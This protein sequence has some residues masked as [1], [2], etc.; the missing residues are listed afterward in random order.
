[1]A[2][3][4]AVRRPAASARPLLLLPKKLFILTSFRHMHGQQGGVLGVFL[5]DTESDLVLCSW[6]ATGA[7]PVYVD[8]SQD[9]AMMQRVIHASQ[10]CLH[11]GGEL[12]PKLLGPSLHL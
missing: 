5:L 8:N 10:R 7:P 11:C 6:T 9:V 12:A 1:M 3:V 4:E 2:H